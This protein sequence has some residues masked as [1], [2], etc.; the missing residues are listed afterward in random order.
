MNIQAWAQR[1]TKSFEITRTKSAEME[2]DRELLMARETLRH[3]RNVSVDTIDIIQARKSA[4]AAPFDP[5]SPS[6][7]RSPL[8]KTRYTCT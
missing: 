7:A 1:L 5:R 6:V 4:K 2:C 8:V 3:R